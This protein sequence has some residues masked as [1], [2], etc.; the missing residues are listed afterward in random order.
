MIKPEERCRNCT[1]DFCF[2]KECLDT[3][4][5]RKL[6]CNCNKF[7]PLD[8]LLY[9]EMKYLQMKQE[10]YDINKRNRLKYAKSR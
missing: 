8:N 6:I 5:L 4:S 9:L 1:W 7:E 2:H 3:F 10:K